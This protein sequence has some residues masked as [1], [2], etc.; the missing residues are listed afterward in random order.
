M[1]FQLLTETGQSHHQEPAAALLTC[2]PLLEQISCFAACPDHSITT[3]ADA[4]Q[5]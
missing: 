3:P 5:S 2:A 4:L 1:H